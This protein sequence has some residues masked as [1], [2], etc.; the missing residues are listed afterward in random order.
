MTIRLRTRRTPT[1]AA[2]T[3][4]DQSAPRRWLP[5]AK[6]KKLS[7][8]DSPCR[9]VWGPSADRSPGFGFGFGIGFSLERGRAYAAR[10][11]A[12]VVRAASLEG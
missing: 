2:A 8:P 1:S 3:R 7:R 9:G 10:A 5:H 11:V 6:D 4:S 12:S